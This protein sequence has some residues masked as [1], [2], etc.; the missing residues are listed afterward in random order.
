MV[1][2]FLDIETLPG[3]ES[4]KEELGEEKW[5]KSQ[6]NGD[7]GQILCIGYIKE[8]PEGI[9]R[10]VIKGD[11]SQML[12]KLRR[13]GKGFI[14][15][16]LK[17]GEPEILKK[18]WEVAKDADLFIGHN[19]LD[20]DL[21]FIMKRSIIHRVKPTK[22]ISF[23][24]YHNEPVYDTMR[25]WER[26]SG[27]ISLDKMAKILEF[28]S[29]KGELD[30]SKVYDYYIEGRLEEIYAYCMADVELTRKIYNRMNFIEE[31]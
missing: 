17:R 31:I 15:N 16:P 14:P 8:T 3:E 5:G 29:S 12:R 6:L 20:F 24:R 7:Y 21:K 25:E 18:F 10:E 22:D 1:R 11:E 30:G 28:K 13:K 26:W 4:L 19:V 27:Y 2:L 9:T 23:A